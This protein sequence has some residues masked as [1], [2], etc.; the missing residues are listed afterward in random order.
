MTFEDNTPQ[1]HPV[2]FPTK[3]TAFDLLNHEIAK[4]IS[5]DRMLKKIEAILFNP[6]NLRSLSYEQLT[7][8]MDKISF[9]Q[10]SSRNFILEFYKV[11]SKSQAILTALEKA[12]VAEQKGDLQVGSIPNE[13][14][15][16]LKAKV[17]EKLE[18]LERE[19]D[20]AQA[21]DNTSGESV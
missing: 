18:E 10:S 2:L 5:S 21:K 17:I 7:H 4:T 13:R 19:E 15:K 3:K 9:R 1:N 8:L 6:E 20:L 12:T 11:S 14:A 16:A